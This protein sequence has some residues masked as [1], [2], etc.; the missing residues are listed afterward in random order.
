MS[1][2]GHCIA[3]AGSITRCPAVRT[4]GVAQSVLMSQLTTMLR[5]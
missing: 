2:L 5:L 4:Y 1:H 3:P